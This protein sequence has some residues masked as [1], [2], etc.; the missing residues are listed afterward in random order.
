MKAGKKHLDCMSD[1]P[2][3]SPRCRLITSCNLHTVLELTCD[4]KNLYFH[5]FIKYIENPYFL[6]MKV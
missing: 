3:I 1:I 6:H 2:K 4:V 5:D